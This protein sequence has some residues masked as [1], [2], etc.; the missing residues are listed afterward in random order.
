[1][2]PGLP[3]VVLVLSASPA[4][5]AYAQSLYENL[6]RMDASGAD[7]LLVAEPPAGPEWTAVRDRLMRA[8]VDARQP[9]NAHQRL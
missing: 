9:R 8:Q 6:H 5:E 2:G 7:R 4:A 3:Q 1:V